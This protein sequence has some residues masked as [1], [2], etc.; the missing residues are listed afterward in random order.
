LC[1]FSSVVRLT[2][3]PPP[4]SFADVTAAAGLQTRLVYGASGRN[5]YILE[6][7]G[8][9]VAF[10]DYDNDGWP[11][12]FLVNGSTLEGF[13]KGQ[14]PSNHLFRNNRDGTFADVTRGAGLVQAGWGQG[15]VAADYDNDGYDDLFVTYWGQNR[16][17]RNRGNGT[18]EDVTAKAGLVSERR[19]GTSAAFGDYDNDG[20]VDLYVANYIEFDPK[21]AL[22]P[23]AQVPGVNC[24]YRG[25]A[26]MCGPRGLKG[27][28]DR[29]YRN[30][31]KGT[32]TDV[33]IQAGDIDKDSFRGLG[34][35]WGDVNND[36]FLDIVVANDVQ[37]NL[38]YLNRRDGSFQETALAA[39][40]AVD[41]DG[42]ERAGMGV[43]LADYDNDGWL[44]LA[45][46]NFYGEPHSLYSNQKNASFAEVTWASGVGRAT[47]RHLGWG[48]RFFDYDNDGWK[49][50]L[51]VNGHVY[52]EVDAH[53]LDES[54][55]EPTVL[56]R[57]AGNG[58]FA[59]VTSAVGPAL[60]GPRPGRGMAVSDY[61]NDGDLDVL[62]A[63]VNGPPALLENRGGNASHWLTVALQGRKSNRNGIGAR[64]ILRAGNLSLAEEVRSGGSY[65]SQSDLRVHFGLGAT[66]ATASVE[67]RWPGGH[68]DRFT[69]VPVDRVITVKE[70]DPTFTAG[71]ERRGGSSQARR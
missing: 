27:Q 34:I 42:R 9:G 44:D 24:S 51:L 61:D 8:T 38:L 47:M 52:P 22:L 69:D 18:F 41:E 56:L 17:Y 60:I 6:T 40:V 59:D 58:T 7:T 57:N 33:T 32:F 54:Y 19:W 39:G 3:A 11:D 45:I 48:T 55:A 2:S 31:G 66:A 65:L 37:P 4:V 64:V 53:Q 25:L 10:F 26:V 70:G 12:I 35:V 67:I 16:L 62:I 28:R 14:E 50:L 21:T 5:T 20:F 15:A 49:D 29:L 23:G 36:G 13:P 43:D 71:P 68:V 1:A 30:T 46:A 63:N